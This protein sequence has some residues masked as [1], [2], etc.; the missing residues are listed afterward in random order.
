[1]VVVVVLIVDVVIVGCNTD[2]IAVESYN[3]LYNGDTLPEAH[4][5]PFHH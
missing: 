4:T 1:M 3:T 5:T 2:S